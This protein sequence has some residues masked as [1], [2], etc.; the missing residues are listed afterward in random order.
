VKK[1][2]AALAALAL[3]SC[4]PSLIDANEQGGIV[5]NGTGDNLAE[6]LAL[7]NAHC[8]QYGQVALETDADWLTGKLRFSCVAP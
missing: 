3:A 5:K 7:A 6:A 2:L 8:R 1:P 4:A